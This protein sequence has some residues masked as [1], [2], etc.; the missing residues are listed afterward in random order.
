MITSRIFLYSFYYNHY[1][2]ALCQ[3]KPPI[4]THR[5]LDFFETKDNAKAIRS[6]RYPSLSVSRRSAYGA[7]LSTVAAVNAGISTDLIL[8]VTLSYCLY[9][10][11][12]CTCTTSD[13]LIR[14][15]ISHFTNLLYLISLIHYN[16]FYRKIKY[17]IDNSSKPKTQSSKKSDRKFTPFSV[18]F[19]VTVLF[20]N[21]D[22]NKPLT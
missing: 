13:A 11:F 14:N 21:N 1:T 16:I 22:Y 12:S 8:A 17:I 18:S 4:Q 7:D 2:V 5:Q 10:T 6:F 19:S 3:K 15:L 20:S 9:G